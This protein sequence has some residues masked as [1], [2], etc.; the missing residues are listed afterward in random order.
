MQNAWFKH[1]ALLRHH[2]WLGHH[3]SCSLRFALSLSFEPQHCDDCVGALV[4]IVLSASGL[5]L[6]PLSF[7]GLFCYCLSLVMLLLLLFCGM[8]LLWLLRWS[9]FRSLSVVGGCC[10]VRSCCLGGGPFAF[11]GSGC[12]A[13]SLVIFSRIYFSAG[14]AIRTCSFAHLIA[15]APCQTQRLLPSTRLTLAGHI[16]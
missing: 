1:H 10:P 16:Q 9:R 13:P 4:M 15:V 11:L 12:S 3:A 6:F 7:C 14:D 2:T 8:V 5:V